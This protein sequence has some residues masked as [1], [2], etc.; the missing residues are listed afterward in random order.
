M[1]ANGDNAKEEG[2]EEDWG[3]RNVRAGVLGG[4]PDCKKVSRWEKEE[5][6]NSKI[7]VCEGSL[8]ME[9]LLVTKRLAGILLRSGRT[10]N[11]SPLKVV[12]M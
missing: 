6:Q 4:C 9:F 2:S 8:V 3:D 11:R 7:V 5:A 12:V 10:I 1:R